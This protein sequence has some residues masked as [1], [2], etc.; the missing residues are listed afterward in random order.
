MLRRFRSTDCLASTRRA[1]PGWRMAS[2]GI[3]IAS[4]PVRRCPRC[5]A[6]VQSWQH[7]DSSYRTFESSASP[8]FN[9]AG[10]LIGFQGVDRDIT[11]RRH[12]EE[13]VEFLAHHDALTGLPNRILLRDR[14]EH[15]IAMAE[16]SRSR[17]A[18]LFLDLDK[19]KRVN[20]TL[21]HAGGDLLLLEVVTCLG[22]CTRETDTISRQGGDEFIVLL[23]DIPD[24]EAVERIADEI[25]KRL[26]HPVAT[27]GHALNTSCSIGITL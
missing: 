16:R 21:G 5:S 17:V 27:N 9:E 22:R 24:P 23:N 6:S 10:E 12:A 11:E 2:I 20:D 1:M 25:L 26:A 8:L 7:R 19:F 13:R 4:L 3:G 18:M 14:F 15:A